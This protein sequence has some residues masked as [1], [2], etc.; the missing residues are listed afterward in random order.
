M[1][2]CK[3]LHLDTLKSICHSFAHFIR[4][5]KSSCTGEPCNS[6]LSVSCL[7]YS[8]GGEENSY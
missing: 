7:Q 4:V 5:V 3:M 1:V 6:L 8:S 2:T